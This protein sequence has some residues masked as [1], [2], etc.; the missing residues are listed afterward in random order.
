MI[1]FTFAMIIALLMLWTTIMLF[2]WTGIDFARRMQSHEDSL[3]NMDGMIW[4]YQNIETSP[5][6]QI[7]PI[8][9]SNPVK[10]NAIF[11][12]Q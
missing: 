9:Y 10:M 4:E 12:G 1:E 8:F 11:Q 2:R 7:N 3:S 6:K 5:A